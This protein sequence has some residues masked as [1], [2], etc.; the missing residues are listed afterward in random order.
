MTIS[1]AW[2]QGHQAGCAAT[3]GGLRGGR[4]PVLARGMRL[5]SGRRYQAANQ[6]QR[7]ENK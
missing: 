5:V 6:N 3:P 2:I 7:K 4:E 1:A